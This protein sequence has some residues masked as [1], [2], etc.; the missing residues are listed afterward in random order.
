M[1]MGVDTFPERRP[2]AAVAPWLVQPRRPARQRWGKARR[3]AA[4]I[5]C[6]AGAAVLGIGK[7]E[8]RSRESAGICDAQTVS[9]LADNTVR[10]KTVKLS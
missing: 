3:N 1:R 7:T 4:A 10:A 5:G 2:G 6:A 9:R 8:I